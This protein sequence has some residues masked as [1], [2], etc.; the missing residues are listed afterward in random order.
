MNETPRCAQRVLARQLHVNVALPKKQLS[1][2]KKLISL[3]Q[4]CSTR[5]DL[6]KKDFIK[7]KM[8]CVTCKQIGTHQAH[9]CTVRNAGR[10]FSALA[11][12]LKKK[13]KKTGKLTKSEKAT[14]K[15]LLAIAGE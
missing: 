13:K 7:G 14:V 2:R 8:V 12:V 4:R 1:E 5:P 15:K 10:H 11:K 9:Q 3:N 6:F